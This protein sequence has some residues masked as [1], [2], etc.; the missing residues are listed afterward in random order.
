MCFI[1]CL[2]RYVD[3]L[4]PADLNLVVHGSSSHCLESF[5]SSLTYKDDPVLVRAVNM[6]CESEESGEEEQTCCPDWFYI[7]RGDVQEAAL[8]EPITHD[9]RLSRLTAS[10]TVF[11][12]SPSLTSAANSTASVMYS[13]ASSVASWIQRQFSEGS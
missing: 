8:P 5:F 4:Y 11:A 7:Q 3:S 9:R 6:G 13:T 2:S 10:A 12:H 1:S